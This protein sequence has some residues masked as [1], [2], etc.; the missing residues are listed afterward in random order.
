MN[1]NNCTELV[2]LSDEY[3]ALKYY[4]PPL[5]VLSQKSSTVIM[6]KFESY[7]QSSYPDKPSSD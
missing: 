5:D 1:V 2:Q 3:P 4:L 7:V 6:Q